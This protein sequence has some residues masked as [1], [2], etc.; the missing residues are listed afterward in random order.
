MI[1]NTKRSWEK[2]SESVNVQPYS[3]V[4]R[5]G[6]R[7]PRTKQESTEYILWGVKE[8]KKEKKCALLCV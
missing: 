2:Q 8:E 7:H 4:I 3:P 1:Y 5:L 6:L